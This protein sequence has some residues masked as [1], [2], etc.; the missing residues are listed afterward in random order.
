M[1]RAYP[2]VVNSGSGAWIT[3]V[4]GNTFLDFTAGIAVTTTGHSHPRVL[5]AI[6][7]QAALLSRLFADQAIVDAQNPI[8]VDIAYAPQPD[9]ALP[10]PRADY[11]ATQTPLLAPALH[12]LE[13]RQT[14][15]PPAFLAEPP[16]S[17]SVQ[18]LFQGT[19]PS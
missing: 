13:Q 8:I 14:F 9:L 4:D 5:A 17:G 18:V 15:Y 11:Y 2:L 7:Q 1:T 12:P 10:R 16:T 3:D 19:L 6:Q